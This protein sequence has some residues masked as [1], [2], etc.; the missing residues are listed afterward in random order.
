MQASILDAA[1]Q[2]FAEH[3]YDGASLNGI[4]VAAGLSKGAFYYY[5]DDKADLAATVLEREVRRFDLADLREVASADEFWAE[6]IRFTRQQLEQLRES[7]QR[8][9]VISRLGVAMAR[10]PEL[11]ARFGPVIRELQETM[12][13]FWTRG[14]ELGAVRR[15]LP[16][17][18][19]I[20]LAQAC[21][22][23]LTG[24]LLP[25]ERG[26]TVDELEEF[27]RIHIDMVRR[28]TEPRGPAPASEVQR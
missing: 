19:L 22:T 16:V 11:L 7:P 26:A 3:G 27:A 2:E 4:L 17:A 5:F 15:D 20:A 18:L 10:S 25:A 8:T 12:V 6:V 24:A 1:A 23:T 28:I 21:K 14:Q 9:D 13:G